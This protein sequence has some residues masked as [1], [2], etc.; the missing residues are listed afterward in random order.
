MRL[1]TAVKSACFLLLDQSTIAEGAKTPKGIL[2]TWPIPDGID[3]FQP[4]LN[5]VN[6]TTGGSIKY[7]SSLAYFDFNGTVE[8]QARYFRSPVF[9]AVIRPYSLNLTPKK[10]GSVVTFTLDEPRDIVVQVNDNIFDALH[11]FTNPPDAVVPSEGDKDVMYYGPGY[12]K[13]NSTLEVGSGKTLYVAGGAVV[14]VPDITVT[15]SSDVTIRGRGLLYSPKGNYLNVYR[16][17]NVLID[18]LVGINFLPRAYESKDVTFSHWCDFSAVQWGDGMDVYCCENVLIDSVFL[19]NSDDCIA[20]YAHRNQWYGNSTNVTIQNSILWADVVHPINIG[21]HGNTE[22]PETIAGLTIRN[23]DILDQR[24]GQVDYQGTIALNP[25]GGNLIQDVLIDDVRVEDIR[26]GQLLN[27]RVMYNTKYNTSPGRGIKNVLVRDL[28]YPGTK[29][30]MSIFV[31]Y[32]EDR[33]ISNVTFENL[34]IN[35]KVISDNMQ[36]PGWYLTTDFIPAYAN[37]HVHN[38]TFTST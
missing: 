5:E 23:I 22:D 28:K 24:E 19:R 9:K 7:N 3:T 36:K 38:M 2:Q 25:G 20:V 18:R 34:V 6:F 27:F 16:S 30:S 15:N 4:I 35:G 31:G 33:T 10:S 11:I 17:N 29:A 13:L 1:S 12:H 37:E 32:D 8:I 14:S 21:T 26:V